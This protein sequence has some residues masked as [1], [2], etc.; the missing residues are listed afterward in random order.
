MPVLKCDYVTCDEGFFCD[1]YTGSCVPIGQCGKSICTENEWCNRDKC[2][3]IPGTYPV[4]NSHYPVFVTPSPTDP[5]Y[6]TPGPTYPVDVT[7]GPTVT[8]RP[9]DMEEEP[10]PTQDG[11]P[12]PPIGTNKPSTGETSSQNFGNTEDN[13]G[14]KKKKENNGPP[15]GTNKPSTGGTSS[16][17][18]GNTED[19]SGAKEKKKKNNG[20]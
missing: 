2:E 4:Y 18:F 9:T 14:A 20:K 12:K 10:S 15:I 6:E 8:P 3:S 11:N 1:I 13:S 5:V 19:N 16:Q 7:R 17:N